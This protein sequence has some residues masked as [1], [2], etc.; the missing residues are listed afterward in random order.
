MEEKDRPGTDIHHEEE[1]SNDRVYDLDSDSSA[2]LDETAGEGEAAAD[3]EDHRPKFSRK[4]I[5]DRFAEKNSAISKLQKEKSV[6]EKEKQAVATERA[7]WA[8]EKSALE[9][10]VKENKDKWLR[11]A[12]EFEN[13]RKRT[14]KEW[15]LLKQQ[16][17]TEVILEVLNSLDDFERAFAVV[18]PGSEDDFMKGVRLIYNNLLQ[19]LQK[20]GVV[21][22]DALHKPFDPVRH[23][24]IGQIETDATAPGNVAQVI[25]KGYS[26]NGSVIR[27]AHVLVAK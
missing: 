13:Y 8:A 5:L 12:A 23:M 19:V 3:G 7:G 25:T 26:F 22:V 10:Q 1:E 9:A 20:M 27:P 21:E 6:L 17:R 11:G 14:A 16:S 2:P 4:Q 15:E 18:E 24:A